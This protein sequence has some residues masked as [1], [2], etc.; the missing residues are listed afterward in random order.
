MQGSTYL[1]EVLELANSTIPLLCQSALRVCWNWLSTASPGGEIL[2]L[3][4][5][6]LSSRW[7]PLS[8]VR[9]N[10]QRLALVSEVSM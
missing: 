1:A 9:K 7:Y 8:W 3:G 6:G 2:K 4:K 5:I 10:A